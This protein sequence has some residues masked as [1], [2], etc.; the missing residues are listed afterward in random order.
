MLPVERKQRIRDI[1]LRDR[2]VVVAELSQQFGVTDETVRRDL[3]ALE[4]EGLIERTHGGA[5]ARDVEIED[6]PYPVR[7]G[8]NLPAKRRIALSARR[9][10]KDGDAVMIDSSSTAFQLLPHL[11]EH[12]DLTLITNSVRILG[13]PALVDHTIMSVGGELRQQS[14]TFVGPLAVQALGRFNADIAFISAKAISMTSGLMDASVA[15]AEIKRAFVRHA[16]QVCLLVDGDK[17]DGVGLISVCDFEP[18]A[19]VVTD[20][21]PSDAWI[22]FLAARQVRLLYETT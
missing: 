15:D 8:I 20:R 3:Q 13:E 12:K 22:D 16:R 14:M 9:L 21:K 5:I 2:R 6:L 18:V 7:Q 1:V 4:R 10:I 19:I 11:R 17:F